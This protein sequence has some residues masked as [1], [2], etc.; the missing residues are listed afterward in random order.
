MQKGCRRGIA[1]PLSVALFFSVSYNQE[2]KLYNTAK[3]ETN[4]NIKQ[5]HKG[6]ATNHSMILTDKRYKQRKGIPHYYI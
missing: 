2:G 5:H 3:I 6:K 1:S 4:S